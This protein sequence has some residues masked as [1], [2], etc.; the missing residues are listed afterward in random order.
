MLYPDLSG[1]TPGVDVKGTVREW[2]TTKG[3]AITPH[4]SDPLPAV[5]RSLHVGG[6]GNVAVR[7]AGDDNDTLLSG[8]VA[9]QVYPIQ[10]SHVRATGTTATLLTGLHG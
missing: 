7:L 3:F 9:G 4:D 8:C 10:V 2:A 6:A 5:A 1:N